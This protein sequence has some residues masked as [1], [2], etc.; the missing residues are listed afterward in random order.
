MTSHICLVAPFEQL[1]G[2]AQAVR[3]TCGIEF[4]IEIANLED[5]VALLPQLEARNY[6]VLVSRGKT[7]EILRR[8]TSL[9]VIDIKI[10][11]YDIVRVLADLVGR[12][13]RV[14]LVGH[15]SV[16][17]ECVKIADMLRIPSYSILFEQNDALEYET[18]RDDV[19]QRLADDPIDIM[20]GD[21]IPQS[22]F[23]DLC[24]QFRLLSSG[25][26]S[27]IEG[28]E[29]AQAFL[30]MLKLERTNRD[31][32]STVL[33]MFEK[34][35]FSLDQAGTIVHANRNAAA[36]FQ[37]NRADMMGKPIEAIDPAL[38]IARDTIADGI[39]QVG[40]VVE[41]RQGRMVCYLYPITSDGECYSIVFALERVEQLYTIEKKV[42]YQEQQ[43]SK[44]TANY[45]LNGYVTYDPAMQAGLELLDN[46]AKTD[47]TVLITGES[48]TGKELLAQGIHNASRRASGPFV[49]VNCGALPPT[50]LESELFG[51]IDGA[52]TG[53]SRRGKKGLFELADKGTLFLDEIGELDKVLQTRLLRVI[54]ERQLMRLGAEQVIPVDIRI[55]A[56]TNQDLEGM[57]AAGTFRQDLFYRLN[58]LKFE[59]LPL[60]MRPRD[61]L[62]SA[63]L[64]L[65]KHARTYQ[66]A[67]VDLDADL[68]QTLLAYDWPGNFRQLSNIMER[69]AITARDP[70]VRLGSVESALSDLRKPV[71][72][73]ASD[74]AG[75][76]AMQGD[77]NA[78]RLRVVPKIMAEENNNK[79]QAARR[80]GVDRGTLNRWLK[81]LADKA[82]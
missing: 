20:I 12:P 39:W 3:S 32:L 40:Q 70:V 61:I 57:V 67:A 62:P 59:T 52:F 42:R 82:V 55:V 8:H 69:I 54:Q 17:R 37:M 56:A 7:A 78:I 23:A 2:I 1:S 9:P 30:N 14:G 29:S 49:A 19:R 36:F 73:I 10:N 81:E 13:C 27:V 79:S 26:E 48:G 18:L 5:A 34:A 65:R 28:I 15:A 63:V 33:D 25:P 53:A 80:L 45:R 64:L 51:Y 76:E 50:L 68:R 46:Y 11:S 71:R 24:G 77:L 66:S 41:T 16:M 47:A 58:V 4:D 43:K 31:H 60:R 74:C 35:V 22:H 72:K 75:C 21:T 44:F 6:Q 38:V